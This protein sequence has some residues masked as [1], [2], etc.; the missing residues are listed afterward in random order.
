MTRERWGAT[1]ADDPPPHEVVLQGER[2]IDRCLHWRGLE[3]KAR[4]G[5]SAGGRSCGYVP[6]SMSGTGQLQIDS[7]QAETVRQIFSWYADGWSTRAI[8]RELNVRA[9]PSPGSSWARVQRR[10]G[11]WMV[12]GI[13]GDVKR[14]VG[15][16]NNQ[17]YRGRVIWNRSRWVRG[18]ADSSKRR[19]VQNPPSEW[20]VREDESLRIVPEELWQRVTDRRQRRAR[21]VGERVRA[22]VSRDRAKRTGREPKFPFSGLL[23]C[24]VCGASFVMAGKDHYACST[25]IYGG[26]DACT[27]DAYLHRSQIEP[28]LMAGIKRELGAPEVLKEIQR[29]L[30]ARLKARPTID[31]GAAIAKLEREVS[32]LVDAIAS[33]VLRTSP[34][35]AERLQVAEIELQRLADRSNSSQPRPGRADTRPPGAA[36]RC[37]E[38]IDRLEVLMARDP[39]ARAPGARYA[40][41]PHASTHH[42]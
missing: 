23:K 34:A 6:A 31:H 40:R 29:R 9:V 42:G 2:G 33:G 39:G 5:K 35:I 17:L 38:A 36:L 20:V 18:A 7:A 41:R 12:S 25:R 13:A 24:G 37:A 14:G 3:G 32:A 4:E 19:C 21:T 10:R 15:I 28:G 11:G 26:V 27:N 16:L 30:R 1:R 22:G 8:A